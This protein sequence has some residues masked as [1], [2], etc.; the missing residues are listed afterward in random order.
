MVVDDVRR[1]NSMELTV[2]KGYQKRSLHGNKPNKMFTEP[3][4]LKFKKGKDKSFRQSL[5]RCTQSKQERILNGS[6]GSHYNSSD[7]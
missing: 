7:L 6:Y 5:S 3:Y 4:T 2:S 1:T